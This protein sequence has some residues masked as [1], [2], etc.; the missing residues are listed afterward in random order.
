MSKR[1]VV[2]GATGNMGTSVVQA[3]N[4]DDDVGSI[5]GLARR[6]TSWR[7]PKMELATADIAE[8]NLVELFSGADV[9]IHL[10]WLFQPTHRSSITWRTNALGSIRVFDAAAEAGVPT[11]VYA[12]SVAAYS[13]GPKD[14]KVDESWPTHGWPAAAYPAE[15]AYVERCLDHVE[16]RHPQMRVVRL[17]PGFCFKRTSASQQRRLFAGPFVPGQLVRPGVIPVVPDLPGLRMQALHTDDVA[18]A[19]RLAALGSAHGAYNVAADPVVDGPAIAGLLGARPVR[20]PAAPVKAALAAA[21][22][23]HMVPASPGLFDTVLRLPLMDT[24]RAREELG[25][26]PRY[27]ST[28]ALR[29]FFTGLREGGAMPTAPLAAHA[30]GGRLG[31][32]RTGVGMRP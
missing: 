21:W 25:W 19:Y 8:T 24:T 28:D 11:L 2:T 6:Q 12:S 26:K 15:K 17:R 20:M 5:V 30:T 16:A 31:E 32:L 9:V 29:E 4:D 22:Y 23:L 3:L 14:R 27:S 13:P 10:A 1:V 18:Q 7:L